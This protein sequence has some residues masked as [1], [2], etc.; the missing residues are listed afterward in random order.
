MIAEQMLQF[1]AEDASDATR[2]AL[3]P[4][5][6][7]E[8][9]Y[10]IIDLGEKDQMRY[11]TFMVK[12]LVK[13]TEFF[14]EDGR[15]VYN[16]PD[17]TPLVE[18]R[19]LPSLN[20]RQEFFR[21]IPECVWLGAKNPDRPSDW[22]VAATDFSALITYFIWPKN[23][24]LY[25]NDEARTH[26][27]FLVLRFAQQTKRAK[28]AANFKINNVMP[29]VP[30]DFVQHSEWPLSDYQIVA[31][32]M[33]VGHES[34]ALFMDP[35]T[36]KTPCGVAITCLESARLKAGLKGKARMMRVLVVC[37]KQVRTNWVE[38]FRKFTVVPGKT[39]I[40]KG[41]PLKRVKLLTHAAK[42]EDD[43][44]FSVAII[45]FDTVPST[46]EALLLGTWD[47]II[48][49]ESHKIKGAR[50]DRYLELVK[51]RERSDQRIIFTGTPIGNSVNDL[52]P[53]LEFL[54]HG[55]S[56]F[57]SKQE[58]KKF[59]GKYVKLKDGAGN[60]V[61]KLVGLTNVPLLQERLSRVAFF[62]TEEEAKL[63]LPD[64]V[65]DIWEV[66]MS[67]HQSTCYKAL[68]SQLAIEIK[69]EIAGDRKQLVAN[70]VLTKLLRLGQITSGYIHWNKNIDPDTGDVITPERTERFAE[71]P[72]RDAV[73]E[74]IASEPVESKIV[75]WCIGKEEIKILDEALTE[76]GIVHGCYYGKTSD[77][78][79]EEMK[80]RFNLDPTFK[81]LIANPQCASEGLNLHGYD[82]N[83]P[84]RFNTYAGRVIYYS[85]NWSFI[86]RY[87]CS[88]RTNRRG[89]RMPVKETD[90][91]HA[92]TIDEEIRKRVKRKG[93]ASDIITDIT[94]IL[95]AI[96]NFS[97]EEQ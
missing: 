97:Y 45:G 70:H 78:D 48:V 81:V 8:D 84:E 77:K 55:L 12:S 91:M 61:E 85:Q 90:L 95:K 67:E 64:I 21:R 33:G 11:F 43:C 32:L 3:E 47:L 36:G 31:T 22:Q 44:A 66:E 17:G 53:Q 58:F 72:K 34:L 79:R 50:T 68:A 80:Q 42:S 63:K 29:P 92:G 60:S 5:E 71:I 18:G 27:Q 6:L 15:F 83:D 14:A 56:G 30:P 24:I 75:I 19:G 74:I 57:T 9:D 38:E 93:E 10:L 69:A 86:D 23:K 88:K 89:S 87:Q 59:H 62:I 2:K 26:F 25:V 13:K 46:I 65:P 1:L 51:L 54:A 94:E 35:G 20:A 73:L 76:K 49:D 41:G 39:T 96:T 16:T 4:I 7:R 37:P 82:V 40:I 52:W 28:M